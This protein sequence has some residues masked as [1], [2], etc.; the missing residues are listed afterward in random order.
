MSRHYIRCYD[1]LTKTFRL[2]L[3]PSQLLLLVHVSQITIIDFLL[4]LNHF[5]FTSMKHFQVKL[6]MITLH[7]FSFHRLF[8]LSPLSINSSLAFDPSTLTKYL[9]IATNP[10]LVTIIDHKHTHT[11]EMFSSTHSTDLF[12]P[13]FSILL[14]LLLLQSTALLLLIQ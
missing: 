14:L 7:L 4:F 6:L 2:L 10:T 13:L 9:S 8:H 1:S 12:N 5:S 11:L 3:M